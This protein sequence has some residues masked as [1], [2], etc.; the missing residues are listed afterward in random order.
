MKHKLL[1]VVAVA[2][3][4]LFVSSDFLYASDDNNDSDS[5]KVHSFQASVSTGNNQ[6][7][8]GKKLAS[9]IFFLKPALH[10]SYKEGFFADLSC[11]YFPSFNKKSIDNLAIGLGYNLDLGNNL[12][13]SLG[14]SY[15]KYFSS[16]EVT[17]SAPNVVDWSLGWDNPIITPSLDASYNF[18]TTHDFSTGIDL[19]HS[20]EIQHLLTK[21]DKLS[22]PI[23][24]ST[25]FA[26]ANFYK[27]YIKNNKITKKAKTNT[28]SKQTTSTETVD[29]TTVNTNFSI[30]DVTLSSGFT[31]SIDGLS[32][33]PSVAYLVPF[34][35]PSDLLSRQSLVLT[36]QIAYSF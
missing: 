14:Y 16:K 19:S 12:S 17:S 33:T 8:K 3:T 23:S 24:V 9:N 2:L 28:K 29:Y 1:F 26:S 31:Y 30:S 22:I 25:T 27:E 15:T 7:S 21:S 20:F 36:F 5:T 32:F 34:H 10:Y 4:L 6:I 13:T 35:Q 18:G 11:A